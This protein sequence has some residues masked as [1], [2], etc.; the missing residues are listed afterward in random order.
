[1]AKEI[2]PTSSMAALFGSRVRRL[3]LAA[4]LTQTEVGRRTHVVGSRITQVERAL[5]AK[6]TW[7]LAQALNEVLESDDLLIDLWPYV[8][9]EAFPDWSQKFMELSARAVGL[10]QY[11]A[12]VVPGLLQTEDYAR[13]LLGVY[14][15]HADTEKLEQ[16]LTARMK[17]QRRIVGPDRPGLWVV[18]DEAVL[19]RPVGGPVV[20]R[21]QLRRILDAVHRRQAIVQV[22]P[23][24]QGAHGSLG[25]SLTLL[26]MPDATEVA[27]KEGS[28]Y[29]Y[30]LEEPTDVRREAVTY[31]QLRA[32]SLPPDMSTD[33]IRSVLEGKYRGANVPSRAARRRVAQ[34]QLQQSGRGRLRGGRRRFPG[35]GSRS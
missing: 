18:L 25:G 7:E 1:M 12:H 14:P 35:R 33:V 24:A 34:E 16:R 26:K 17:R 15:E 20:M 30:L 31:D 10:W 27:Y 3:R 9:R 28:E 11:A 5:G 8:Y 13:A 4:G 21:A 19:M 2:D 29:G 23:F 6:P 32:A 22:L